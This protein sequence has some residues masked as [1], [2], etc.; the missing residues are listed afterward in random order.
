MAA[1]RS[2]SSRATMARI[3]ACAWVNG[4]AWPHAP[5]GVA[6]AVLP[7]GSFLR[8]HGPRHP[9][10]GRFTDRFQTLGPMRKGKAGGHHADDAVGPRIEQQFF[11]QHA[12]IGTEA[13]L[14]ERV[15]D[16]GDLS[17]PRLVVIGGHGAAEFRRD[18]EDL[19]EVSSDAGTVHADTAVPF[20]ER[21]IRSLVN[22][23]RMRTSGFV[24]ASRR[25]PH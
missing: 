5:D 22:S 4:N 2:G 23:A 12:A 15:A 25:I 13:G 1:G 14:P 10:I 9:D 6:G 20:T 18:P 3:S 21:F 7:G 16:H 17:F 8:R 11:P 24:F 19:E